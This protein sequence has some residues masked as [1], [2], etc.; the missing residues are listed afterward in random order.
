MRLTVDLPKLREL[1]TGFHTLTGL[2]IALFDPEYRKVLGYP[3]SEGPFC[4]YMY[5]APATRARCEASNIQ[6]FER[7]RASG[8]L[9]I[10]HCH[11]GLM[12]ATAPIVDGGVVRGYV[13][14][15]QIIDRDD[16][17]AFLDE[18]AAQLQPL[19]L[20][21][22][23]ARSVVAN[24]PSLGAEHIHATARILDA[25]ICYLL[26]YDLVALRKGRLLQRVDT[27]IDA[28]LAED[29]TTERLCTEFH[30]SRSNLYR[31]FADH[32]GDSVAATVKARRMEKAR[33]LLRD[34]TLPL[35]HIAA[36][37]GYEDDAYFR[38]VFRAEHGMSAKA[39]REDAG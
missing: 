26:R 31:L 39:Y 5:A 16:R 24:V 15:G 9:T 22:D 14:F 25:C 27:F 30:L 7:C 33:R 3:E 11:A 23:T 18:L 17:A 4:Q 6:T 12:E 32:L 19:G 29:L 1:M 35:R 34:T 10:S 2:K 20:D 8:R 13:M 36:E 38:R 28:H 21:E 37:C